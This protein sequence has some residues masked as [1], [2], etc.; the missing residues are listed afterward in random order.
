MSEG[1]LER[2]LPSPL[3]KST[4]GEETARILRRYVLDAGLE[5]GDRLPSERALSRRLGVSHRVV[6]EALSELVSDGL[7]HKEH[8]RGAFVQE[9]DRERMALRMERAVPADVE[10]LQEAR[11]ALECG[12]MPLVVARATDSELD[13]LARILERE[14]AHYERGESP[15]GDDIEFHTR[16]LRLA[17]NRMLERFG[18]VITRSLRENI[19]RKPW[20]LRESLFPDQFAMETHARMVAALRSRDAIQAIEAVMVHLQMRELDQ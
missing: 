8:G 20:L 11:R 19:Y 6:R 9:F 13:Q 15:A 14:R 18:A 7:V 4:L 16:L 17:G 10:E 5:P 3:Q 1:D 2:W 12:M